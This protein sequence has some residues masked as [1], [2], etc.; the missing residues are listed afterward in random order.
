MAEKMRDY[1][2]GFGKPP[3]ETQFK[4]GESGNPKGRPKGSKN[5]R[6]ELIEELNMKVR[7]IENGQAQFM[8]KLEAA[9]KTLVN[10]TLSG[11]M[12]ATRL[13]FDVIEKQDPE[14]DEGAG[15][16]ALPL[17]EEDEVLVRR[18][19]ER[20]AADPSLDRRGGGDQ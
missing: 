17:S 8:T 9:I 12:R 19:R 13:L 6:T 16:D 18:L 4:P 10:K 20:A 5:F 11:D 1:E 2:V 14:F 3:K 15:G 7:V